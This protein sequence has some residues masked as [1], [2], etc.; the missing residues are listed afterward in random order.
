MI[1]VFLVYANNFQFKTR[2]YLWSLLL[3]I[4]FSLSLAAYIL[5][6]FAFLLHIRLKLRNILVITIAFIAINYIV[7]H[8]WAGGDNPVYELIYK[9]LE[10]DEDKGI[11]GNN[12]TPAITD[13]Y[14]DLIVKSGD[15]VFGKG[16]VYMGKMFHHGGIQGAGYKMFFMQFG[17]VGTILIFLF[18]AV[19]AHSGIDR[20][21]AYGFLLLYMASFVQRAYPYWLAWLIPYVCAMNYINIGGIHKKNTLYVE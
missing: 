6:I 16:S 11:S 4:L 15:I 5:L 7:T 13:Y 1:S 9:R 14:Y 8:V 12:R 21:Y 10:Y 3:G 20:R 17:I 18:Y 19:I 2:P